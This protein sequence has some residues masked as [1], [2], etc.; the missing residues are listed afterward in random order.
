M[1]SLEKGT[2]ER[3]QL[4]HLYL[5]LRAMPSAEGLSDVTLEHLRHQPRGRPSKR[6]KLLQQITTLRA[7]EHLSLKRLGLPTDTT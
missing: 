5:H 3:H 1:R 4:V 6:G 2:N 7:L